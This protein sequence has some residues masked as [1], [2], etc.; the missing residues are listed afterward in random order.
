[1][2]I[3]N[4]YM[5]Q[6][7]L[8]PHLFECPQRSEGAR[9]AAMVEHDGHGEAGLYHTGDDCISVRHVSVFSAFAA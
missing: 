5:P 9:V 1:M 8:D 4:Y 3:P 2:L 7:V 6:L